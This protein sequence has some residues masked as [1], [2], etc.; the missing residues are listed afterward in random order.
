VDEQDRGAVRQLQA[1]L[2]IYLLLALLTLV[3]VRA[4]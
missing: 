4:V 2:R 3:L 1:F